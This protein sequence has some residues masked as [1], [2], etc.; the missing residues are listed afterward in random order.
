MGYMHSADCTLTKERTPLSPRSSSCV[1]RPYS[2]L[3]MPAQP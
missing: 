3:F 2:T 1:I